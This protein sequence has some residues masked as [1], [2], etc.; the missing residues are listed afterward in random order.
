M[1]GYQAGQRDSAEALIHEVSPVLLRFYLSLGHS[2][3]EAEELLQDAWL[4]IHKARATWR[5]GEKLMP[6]V[7]AIARYARVDSIRRQARV[8]RH[9]EEL[10]ELVESQAAQ[11]ETTEQ[12]GEAFAL[13]AQLPESQRE[14]IVMLKVDG[15]SLEE[16]A[17]ATSSS[18]GAVKQ[19]AHRAYEK[20]RQ[21][22]GHKRLTQG[23]AE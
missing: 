20:L 3:T 23:G 22:L 21:L 9:E 1:T 12:T 18:V 13:L 15:M 6:W 10:T 14:T 5:S 2:R 7:Y 4:R 11:P 8:R 17:R 19:R 16:V